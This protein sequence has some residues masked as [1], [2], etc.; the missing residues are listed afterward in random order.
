VVRPR[1]G[2]KARSG[3]IIWPSHERPTDI[4]QQG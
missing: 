1:Q 2:G 3:G 4:A